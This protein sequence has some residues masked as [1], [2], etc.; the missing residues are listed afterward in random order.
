MKRV[1]HFTQEMIDAM[2]E[3]ILSTRIPMSAVDDPNWPRALND[4]AYHGLAGDV[5]NAILPETE[6]DPVNLLISFL[7]SFGN[8]IG[9]NAYMAIG[10]T[11]HYTNEFAVIVG[12]TST[13]RKG[14][15]SDQIEEMFHR[16]EQ[17]ARSNES[18][19]RC[20]TRGLSTGEGLIAH[21]MPEKNE[22]GE[23]EFVDKRALV[24]EAEF[25]RVLT[26][27]NRPDNTLSSVIRGAW[28]KG[29][30]S[31]MTRKNP[32]FVEDAHVSIIGQI[33]DDELRKHLNVTERANGFGNRFMFAMVRQSKL[34]PFGG[35]PINHDRLASRLIKAQEA[36]QTVDKMRWGSARETWPDFY[37]QFNI[38]KKFGMLGALTARGPSHVLRLAMIYALLDRSEQVETPHLK[39]ALE[40]WR[41]CEDSVKY[42]FGMAIGDDTADT[43]LRELQ[44]FPEGLTRTE[45]I[46]DVFSKNKSS[47]D[48]IRALSILEREGLAKRET[49]K[50]D[51]RPAE[52]WRA[53]IS[54]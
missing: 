5:V 20:I 45:L 43:I 30:L 44:R 37:R 9:R 33:T 7:I 42:V 11:R 12:P 17:H 22:E 1:L 51:R 47:S 46:V 39:A 19:T 13:G 27:M 18:W 4:D 38:R 15:G 31:T 49:K 25:S 40:V 29:I 28:E 8:A 3:P 34:L 10:A 32:L 2:R 53:I 50:T 6:A 48:I 21:L 41:Y 24:L 26:V 52:V 16:T 23:E 36:A 54:S 14:S 35:A